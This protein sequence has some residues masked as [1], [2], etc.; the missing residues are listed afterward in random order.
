MRN[1]FW[2]NPLHPD[3]LT[4]SERL[5]DAVWMAVLGLSEK[6]PTSV[7]LGV[8]IKNVSVRLRL[9]ACERTVRCRKDSQNFMELRTL[10]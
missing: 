5:K 3:P 6:T 2:A 7:V 10:T 9:L 4:V 1:G 8:I